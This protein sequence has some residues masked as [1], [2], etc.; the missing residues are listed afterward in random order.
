MKTPEYAHFPNLNPGEGGLVSVDNALDFVSVCVMSVFAEALDPRSYLAPGQNPLSLPNTAQQKVINNLHATS[1]KVAE[2]Q[3]IWLACGCAIEC[4]WWFN[5]QF[6]ITSIS[7]N[8]WYNLCST[9]LHWTALKLLHYLEIP[10]LKNIA[11]DGYA[12][13]SAVH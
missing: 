4:I 9:T 7:T 6:I 1:I 12:T 8:E 2:H 10:H 3:D 5:Q 13:Y 11:A